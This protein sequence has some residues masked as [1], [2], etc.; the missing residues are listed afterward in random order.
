MCKIELSDT[1][2]CFTV[3]YLSSQITAAQ[4]TQSF[5]FIFQQTLPIY[6]LI[7][8]NFHD[9]MFRLSWG[10]QSRSRTSVSFPYQQ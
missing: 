10:K 8:T 2:V 7:N 4:T 1:W 9:V 3:L 6:S 5:F